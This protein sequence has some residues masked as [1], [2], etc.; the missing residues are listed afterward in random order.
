MNFLHFRSEKAAQYLGESFRERIVEKSYWS[1]V[2]GSPNEEQGVIS[3]PLKEHTVNGRYK[4]TLSG[5]ETLDGNVSGNAQVMLGCIVHLYAQRIHNNS[6][7]K[8]IRSRVGCVIFT[9]LDP[10]PLS[11]SLT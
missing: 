1:V 4:I 11:V 10:V 5:D 3:V 8:R 7:L 6:V 2:I 9:I